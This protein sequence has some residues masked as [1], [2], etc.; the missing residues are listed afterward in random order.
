MSEVSYSDKRKTEA[1]TQCFLRVLELGRSR[2]DKTG[3]ILRYIDGQI[4]N[5]EKED[6]PDIIRLC[7]KGKKAPVTV[8][9]GIEHFQ[10][11]KMSKRKGEKYVSTGRECQQIIQDTYDKGHE[12]LERIGNVSE[13]IQEKLVHSVA[14]Y[15]EESFRR[16][17]TSFVEAFK[18]HLLR[19]LNQVQR[20]RNNLSNIAGG[21]RIEL[22]LLIE[23]QMRF[24][25]L[26]VNQ[27]S[28]VPVKLSNIL[29][30]C[31]DIVTELEKVDKRSV[32]YIILYSS[33]DPLLTGKDRKE[34]VVAIRTGNIRKHLA[35][36]KI[37]VYKYIE[38]Y[39]SKG[40]FTPKIDANRTTD[41]NFQI[42]RSYMS[43]DD[44]KKEIFNSM[45]IGAYKVSQAQ[46]NGKP[47]VTTIETQS[48]WEAIQKSIE[49]FEKQDEFISIVFK[50]GTSTE[51]ILK[52]YSRA[53]TKYKVGSLSD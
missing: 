28:K 8:V 21:S 36:Q 41:G 37:P 7:S 45:V 23:M 35:A 29:P 42:T 12:E 24:P 6:S 49:G 16:D 14:K 9:V 44:R 19:H 46:K 26:I 2:T 40:A 17:Y 39:L 20:Y 30:V 53:M 22:A 31:D 11:H 47:Y 38:G 3:E 33:E 25:L 15:A 13:D 5:R 1:E 48:F 27:G 34:E 51:E 18:S 4:I 52:N 50:N 10:V 32:D 43:D